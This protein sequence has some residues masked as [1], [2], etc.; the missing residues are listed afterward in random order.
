LDDRALDLLI[1]AERVVAGGREG[2]RAIGVR[3]GVIAAL[4]PIDASA[5]AAEEITIGADAVVLPGVVDTH[6][7]VCEPGN[8]AWEGFATATA[9]AAAG[10][11]TTLVDMPIDSFPATVD[12]D[13]LAAKRHATEGRLHVDVG[14]WGGV[15]P[16]SLG[17]MDALLE[18]GVVGF[19][20]FLA[21]S[22]AEDFAPLDDQSLELALAV[23]ARTGVPLMVHAEDLAGVPAPGPSRRYADWLATRPR[24]TEDR[25]VTRVL[26]A[27]RRTGGRA[28][29][30]HLSSATAL[31]ALAAARAEGVAVTAETCP[32]YLL[33]SAEEIGDGDTAAKCSPPVRDAAN[34]TALWEGL[35][36]GVLDAVVSDHSPCLPQMKSLDTGD[37][38]TAWAGISSLQVA[39]PAA[40]TAA[41]ARGF[42]LTDLVRWMAEAPADLAGLP[43]KGRIVVG[44]DADLCVMAPEEPFVV[45]RSCLLHRH[46]VCPYVGKELFGIVRA[47]MLRGH[48]LD[49]NSSPLGRLVRRSA[50]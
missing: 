8:A 11:I 12:P 5:F 32:H 10:G 41:R 19:K 50:A 7:H 43:A 15:V 24:A 39:L 33:L 25:A 37:F 21:D 26:E 30:A 29:I 38:S 4:L 2:P 18:A 6:V 40:W 34:R 22:G 46:P 36:A 44:A 13:A 45:D 9:A 3:G 48:W 28:H 20:C 17:S 23:T 49:A 16:T 42:R 27:T 14:F 1:R 47:T 31:P 35:A